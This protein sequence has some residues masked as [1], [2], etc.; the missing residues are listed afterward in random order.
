M[1]YGLKYGVKYEVSVGVVELFIVMNANADWLPGLIYHLTSPHR[2]VSV[3]VLLEFFWHDCETGTS[4]DSY[5]ISAGKSWVY[6]CNLYEYKATTQGI[7]KTHNE[8]VHENVQYSC[9]LCEYKT[10]QQGHLN[11]HIESVHEKVRYPCIQCH[12]EFITQ[13]Y[14]KIY[15]ESVQLCKWEI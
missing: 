6:P 5:W 3:L 7:L 12:K 11:T 13:G 4:E 2:V 15:I 14:L 10:K 8:S 9:N 1:I